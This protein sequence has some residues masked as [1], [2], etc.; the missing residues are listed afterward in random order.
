MKQLTIVGLTLAL[1]ITGVQAQSL[2]LRTDLKENKKAS[3]TAGLIAPQ[4]EL[5][6]YGATTYPIVEI[7]R[8]HFQPLGERASVLVGGY[9]SYWTVPHQTYLEP[10]TIWK[11]RLG[12]T[13]LYA[14][15][16]GYAPIGKGDWQTYGEASASWGIAKGLSVGPAADWW[17]TDG[18][19]PTWGLGAS[20]TLKGQHSALTVR[21]LCRA[22]SQ[23]LRIEVNLF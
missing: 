19:K 17:L 20:A 23:E 16:A 13:N 9:L 18:Q 6:L 2:T 3:Y 4:G 21:G 11:G 1:L 10:F 12:K 7:G 8:L 14:K 5:W 22:R 15:I